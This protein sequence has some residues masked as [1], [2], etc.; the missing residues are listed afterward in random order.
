MQILK[1]IFFVFLFA[2]TSCARMHKSYYAEQVNTKDGK[3]RSQGGVTDTGLVI[4]GE[5]DDEFSDT[6]FGLIHFVFE[7]KSD[8]WITITD[9]EA[10]F[11]PKIN[12]YASFL[13]P[14]NKKNLLQIYMKSKKKVME[15][16]EKNKRAWASALT[17]V[18]AMGVAAAHANNG[19]NQA[20]Q[21]SLAQGAVA[22]AAI[23]TIKPKQKIIM[24]EYPEGHLLKKGEI[25]IPPGLFEE[26]WLI[27]NTR[28]HQEIGR[29]NYIYL[30]YK[31]KRSAKETVKLQ[32]RSKWGGRNQWQNDLWFN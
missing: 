8:K 32:L 12:K 2:V 24:E 19:N 20:A 3:S 11:E 1:A 17:G 28:N 16:K 7:N 5:Y 6:Y 13:S 25:I 26:R 30:A 23:N 15:V 10:S 27:V 14:K 9:I 18:A 29:I 31:T 21:K 22:I 4:S